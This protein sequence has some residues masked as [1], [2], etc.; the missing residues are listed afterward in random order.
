[1]HR[2]AP[3]KSLSQPSPATLVLSLRFLQHRRHPQ[4]SLTW[5]LLM[6]LFIS[7]RVS[8][9][10]V[11]LTRSACQSRALL[12]SNERRTHRP[13]QSTR[14]S[15]RSST[16][17]SSPVPASFNLLPLPGPVHDLHGELVVLRDLFSCCFSSCSPLLALTAVVFRR[18]SSS[19]PLFRPAHAQ[20]RP[21]RARPACCLRFDPAPFR[22][23]SSPRLATSAEA[24]DPSG[25]LDLCHR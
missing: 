22:T 3:Y 5:L 15:D 14:A 4:L 25:R 21:V 17:G 12:L 19:S 10:A 7:I 24:S 8:S 1:M 6:S 2:A 18:S 20:A 13:Q 11:R 16:T 23:S 9:A